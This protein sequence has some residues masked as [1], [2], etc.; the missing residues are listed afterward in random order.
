MT[1]NDVQKLRRLAIKPFGHEAMWG[2]LRDLML[3]RFCD[4]DPS[5]QNLLPH[6]MRTRLQMAYN[7]ASVNHAL[8]RYVSNAFLADLL[9]GVDDCHQ[10]RALHFRD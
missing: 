5:A 3:Q 4:I 1:N 9:P 6:V 8:H 2:R 7:G 10:S